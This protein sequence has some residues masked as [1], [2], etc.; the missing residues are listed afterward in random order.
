MPDSQPP[1]TPPAIIVCYTTCWACKFDQHDSA[2]HPWADFEDIEHAKL[3]G[4]EDPSDQKCGCY[5]CAEAEAD[6]DA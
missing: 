4:Q 3:T 5:C 6:G 2:W 1:A